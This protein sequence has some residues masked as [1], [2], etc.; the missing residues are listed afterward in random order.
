MPDTDLKQIDIKIH[1]PH[2]LGKSV[3]EESTLLS[4]MKGWKFPM[5]WV[6]GGLYVTMGSKVGFGRGIEGYC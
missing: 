3:D 4:K 6:L 2:R 5:E 1:V